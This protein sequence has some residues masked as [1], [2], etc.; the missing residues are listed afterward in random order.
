MSEQRLIDRG[1]DW[2]PR[3]HVSFASAHPGE[4]PYTKIRVPKPASDE[5]M[6]MF[7]WPDHC[8]RSSEV[9]RLMSVNPQLLLGSW[10]KR[11]RDRGGR[12]RT[13]EAVATEGQT[14]NRSKG[15]RVLQD[16]Y[17]LLTIRSKGYNTHV[18]A[19]SAFEGAV[20]DVKDPLA[21]RHGSSL[22]IY[23]AHE[24]C[25]PRMKP[26]FK[27]QRWDGICSTRE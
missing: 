13:T 25:S 23:L 24:Q 20:V 21:V 18:D 1:Q 6:D 22:E 27:D 8:V 16:A 14:G 3:G 7:I 11:R 2:H 5:E 4:K 15:V 17:R 12:T 19:F 26:M 10:N 9:P